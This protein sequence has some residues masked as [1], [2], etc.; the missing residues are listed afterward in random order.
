MSKPLTRCPLCAGPVQHVAI[1]ELPRR[2]PDG[3]CVMFADVPATRCEGC[4]EQFFASEVALAMQHV[5]SGRTRVR[6]RVELPLYRL[7]ARLR[8]PSVG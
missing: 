3:T 2:R 5:L 7:P 4:G 8:Q 1:R 6:K